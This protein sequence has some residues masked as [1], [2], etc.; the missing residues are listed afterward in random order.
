MV[1]PL[2]GTIALITYLLVGETIHYC[3]T[4]TII[5]LRFYSVCRLLC[6]TLIHL[7]M[8]YKGSSK[9]LKMR[10]YSCFW[11]YYMELLYAFISS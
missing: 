8:K 10:H 9:S 2:G 1:T 6:N 5:P 7:V 4:K 11:K 3:S